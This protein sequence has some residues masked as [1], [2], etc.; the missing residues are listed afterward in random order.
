MHLY[1]N[2]ILDWHLEDRTPL[3]IE[4]K[5]NYPWDG[6]VSITVLLAGAKEFT[7]YS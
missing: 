5:T 3:K 7:L 2:S 4:Q 1:D 6:D